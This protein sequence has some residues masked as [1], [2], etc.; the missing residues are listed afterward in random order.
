[1]KESI[2]KYLVLSICLFI[3]FALAIILFF[4]LYKIDYI[5]SAIGHIIR[6][7]M[8]FIIGI[9]LAYILTPLCNLLERTFDKLFKK[10]KNPSARGKII[11]SLSV[12]LSIIIAV[13]IIDEL[14]CL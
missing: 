12:F 3:S 10:I 4:L 2:K 13:I 11:S 5:K 8:P 7:M 9:I 6:A 14:L 1:M